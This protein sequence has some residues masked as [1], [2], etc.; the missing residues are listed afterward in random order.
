M[1]IKI[2]LQIISLVFQH[3]IIL[4]CYIILHFFPL[5]HSRLSLTLLLIIVNDEEQIEQEE[6]WKEE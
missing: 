1:K 6:A 4:A 2:A 5:E 3:Y